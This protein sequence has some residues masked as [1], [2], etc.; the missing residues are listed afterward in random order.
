M[1]LNKEVLE[2]II[3]KPINNESN[4]SSISGDGCGFG[5]GSGCSDSKQCGKGLGDGL[6]FK[7]MLTWDGWGNGDGD[8]YA[9]YDAS[10]RGRSGGY[11]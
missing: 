3:L 11:R 9:Y 8:G 7:N 6:P 1:R 4:G 10:G 5:D 2:H